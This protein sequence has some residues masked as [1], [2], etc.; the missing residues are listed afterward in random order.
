MKKKLWQK[1][2]VVEIPK[3]IAPMKE[4]QVLIYEITQKLWDK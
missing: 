3:V 4:L 2:A 1:K